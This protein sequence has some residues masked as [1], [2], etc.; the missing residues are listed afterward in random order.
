M[1]YV[2]HLKRLHDAQMANQQSF[3]QQCLAQ[4]YQ[5]QQQLGDIHRQA[6]VYRKLIKDKLYPFQ[7]GLIGQAPGGLS[8][9]VL[10]GLS[11]TLLGSLVTPPPPL[12]TSKLVKSLDMS[13]QSTLLPPNLLV[14][15]SLPQKQ[16]R[17]GLGKPLNS[18][19]AGTSQIPTPTRV[20]IPQPFAATPANSSGLNSFAGRPTKFGR[21]ENVSGRQP[22]LE[23]LVAGVASG[24]Y[25]STSRA[26]LGNTTIAISTPLASRQSSSNVAVRFAVGSSIPVPRLGAPLL[27]VHHHHRAPDVTSATSR[28]A[29]AAPMRASSS[30]GSDAARSTASTTSAVPMASCTAFA[31]SP[32]SRS[33]SASNANESSSTGN[34]FGGC[35]DIG[36]AGVTDS[37]GLQ[38]EPFDFSMKTMKRVDEAGEAVAHPMIS[39]LLLSPIRS[40]ELKAKSLLESQLNLRSFRAPPDEAGLRASKP[41][42][43]RAEAN[44][45]IDQIR[46][47]VLQVKPQTS[48]QTII[49]DTLS[50]SMYGNR[51]LLELLLT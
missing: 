50:E 16:L 27:N 37:P 43:R 28:P 45:W 9:G 38:T 48:L 10:A 7:G 42:R 6:N 3:F 22:Q 2:E 41:P 36:N 25:V 46:G 1:A 5:Q 8:A 44:A 13:N 11:P 49:N 40:G 17:M 31:Q 35:G 4:Q 39:Q 18:P 15:Q 19:L 24:D 20:S 14:G 23:T 34:Y 21:N 29:Y 26:S 12:I 33:S 47:D 51:L 30:S 32:S